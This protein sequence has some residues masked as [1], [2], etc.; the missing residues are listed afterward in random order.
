MS[1]SCFLEEL[2]NDFNLYH[3]NLNVV[4]MAANIAAIAV[5]IILPIPGSKYAYAGVASN[6]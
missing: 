1:F 3:Q 2:K 6:K 5:N 4:T